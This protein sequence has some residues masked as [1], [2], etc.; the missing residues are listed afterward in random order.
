MPGRE[1]L[2]GSRQGSEMGSKD[3]SAQIGALWT[4]REVEGH[5]WQRTADSGPM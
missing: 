5:C 2:R 4:P 1:G 3:H